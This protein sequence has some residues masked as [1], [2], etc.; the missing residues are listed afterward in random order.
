MKCPKC[1]SE[2]SLIHH[3]TRGSHYEW[4]CKCGHESKLKDGE[5]G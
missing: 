1:G 2:M 5:K 3:L 4:R